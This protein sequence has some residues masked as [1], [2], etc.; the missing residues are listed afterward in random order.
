MKLSLIVA[1]SK[2]GVIGNAGMIPWKL[3]TDMQ[4]F[5]SVTIG[6]PIIMGRKTFES[7]PCLLKDRRHIVL[8]RDIFLLHSGATTVTSLKEAVDECSD[9]DV[10][11]IIGGG[12]VYKEALSLVDELIVTEVGAVVEGDTFF[13]FDTAQFE[14]VSRMPHGK[15][16]VDQYNFDI[17]TYKRK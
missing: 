5:A 7:L 17:V 13:E 12:E 8:T 1:R 4:H 10:A 6:H 14:E 9:D 15:S 3:K 11:Y 16:E 2:N